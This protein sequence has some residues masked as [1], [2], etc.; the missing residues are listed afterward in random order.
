MGLSQRNHDGSRCLPLP[1]QGF[2]VL[3]R[4]SCEQLAPNQCIHLFFTSLCAHEQ[5]AESEAVFK[6][7]LVRR[8]VATDPSASESLGTKADCW[9]VNDIE[10]DYSGWQVLDPIGADRAPDFFIRP[11]RS[12]E[13]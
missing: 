4:L 13:H 8:R 12:K 11:K 5:E 10:P 2:A 9:M 6:I 1:H 3:P 7:H